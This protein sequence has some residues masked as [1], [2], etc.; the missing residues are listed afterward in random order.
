M[1]TKAAERA[2]LPASPSSLNLTREEYFRL[3]QKSQQRVVASP[4]YDHFRKPHMTHLHAVIELE[5]EGGE[6]LCSFIQRGAKARFYRGYPHW[7]EWMRQT[8]GRR[9]PR[10]S[11]CVVDSPNAPSSATGLLTQ[12]NNTAAK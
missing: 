3:S 8:P 2:A 9:Q 7:S 5:C 11:V 10:L 6:P 1:K 12:P 4:S